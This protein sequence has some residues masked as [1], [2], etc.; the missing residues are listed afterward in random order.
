MSETCWLSFSSPA[1]REWVCSDT[2]LQFDHPHIIRLI[3]VCS[4][5]P[6]WIVMELAA[7]GEVINLYRSCSLANRSP[8]LSYRLGAREPEGQMTP[9]NLPAGSSK[10]FWP[11]FPQDFWERNFSGT[12][13]SWFSAKSLKLLSPCH[14]LS[15]FKAKMHQI[16][17]RLGLCPRPRCGSLQRSPKL[18][19]GFKGASWKCSPHVLTPPQ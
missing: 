5:P 1:V 16:R 4:A 11:L 6:V 13:V 7:L 2:M 3:G 12:Q 9:R 8:G 17:F 15:D 10:V 19:A 18:L 14:Q